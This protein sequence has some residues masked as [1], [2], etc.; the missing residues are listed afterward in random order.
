[1]QMPK[2]LTEQTSILKV[3]GVK[4]KTMDQLFL[5]EQQKKK[6]LLSF[7]MNDRQTLTEDTN[8]LSVIAK[9]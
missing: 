2:G 4:A 6:K 8:P 5:L 9:L 3:K 7:Q 1:M